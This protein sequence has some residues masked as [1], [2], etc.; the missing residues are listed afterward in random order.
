[1]HETDAAPACL[2][3]T[4]H[5][6]VHME[7]YTR[8]GTNTLQ[9]GPAHECTQDMHLQVKSF[10]SKYF[11]E[12]C[13]SSCGYQNPHLLSPSDTETDGWSSFHPL[14]RRA[15]DL[16]WPRL[17]SLASKVVWVS[18]TSFSRL[19][20]ALEIPGRQTKRDPGLRVWVTLN[21][22][23][24]SDVPSISAKPPSLSMD[25]CQLQSVV[26]RAS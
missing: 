13:S 19:H 26:T 6:H 22:R 17:H 9:H 14:P 4:S 16:C 1:M 25:T 11:S 23:M 3:F 15:I 2:A 10:S 24:L 21:P 18:L 20:L 12:F 7:S 8:T 5:L